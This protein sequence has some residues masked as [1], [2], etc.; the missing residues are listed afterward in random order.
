MDSSRVKGAGISTPDVVSYFQS[1]FVIPG[2]EGNK[3]AKQDPAPNTDA[4]SF[5]VDDAL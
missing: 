5:V 2:G 3:C 4:L 1:K